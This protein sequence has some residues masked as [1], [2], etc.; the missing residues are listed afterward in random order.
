MLSEFDVPGLSSLAVYTA[1]LSA[2]PGCH[3]DPVLYKE[4]VFSFFPNCPL[5]QNISC[6][7]YCL[8]NSNQ[9]NSTHFYKVYSGWSFS[10]GDVI[11]SNCRHPKPD[12][13]LT[14]YPSANLSLPELR[15]L[16]NLVFCELTVLSFLSRVNRLISTG[17]EG[18]GGSTTCLASTRGCG[19]VCFI[20]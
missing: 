1:W 3:E 11:S 16:Y 9:L 10:M 13:T 7:I 8:S 19:F 5:L 4:P 17:G 6:I 12:P 2:F 18:K 15:V 14:C 20:P